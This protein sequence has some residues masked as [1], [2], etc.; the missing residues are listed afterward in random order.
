MSDPP[1]SGATSVE[2]AEAAT[3]PPSA[4]RSRSL[5]IA[6]CASGPAALYALL[7]LAHALLVE[8]SLN[9]DVGFGRSLAFWVVAV[10]LALLLWGFLPR[11]PSA[12]FARATVVYSM[13]AIGALGLLVCGGFT[14]A[15]LVARWNPS[16]GVPVLGALIVMLAAGI[17][18]LRLAD[19][20][21]PP[22]S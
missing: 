3:P 4:T 16:V 22:P 1:S 2:V 15:W 19:R 17:G 13:L 21:E 20:S 8:R 6:A 7:S 11:Q 5:V 18:T 14:L 9:V 12:R 10:Y